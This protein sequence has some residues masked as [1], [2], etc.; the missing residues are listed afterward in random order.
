V[1][2][3][4]R[5]ILYLATTVRPSA[6]APPAVHCCAGVFAHPLTPTL[7]PLFNRRDLDN[8]RLDKV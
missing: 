8:A 7:Y 1:L 3:T 5:E 2:V 6:P 4:A